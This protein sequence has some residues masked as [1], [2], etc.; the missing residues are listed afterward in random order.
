MSD[1]VVPDQVD[2]RVW[3][4]ERGL[5]YP[6]P[7]ICHLLDVAAV[8]GALWDVLLHPRLR[9]RVAGELGLGV[10]EARA[11]LAWWAGLHDLGKITPPFQAQVPDAFRALTGD[12]V[13]VAAAG[14]E[15]LAGFR[16]ELGTHW[17]LVSL[18]AEA[19]YPVSRVQARS[20]PHQVA[21]LLGGHHGCFADV[22]PPRQAAA[23]GQYQAGLGQRGWQ[24]QRRC[25]LEAV[26]RVVGAETVPAGQLSAAT[27]VRVYGL[28]VLAD[29]LAS[30]VE[31]I[32]PGLPSRTWPGS[33]EQL[34][35]HYRQ[36]ARDAPGVV[37]TAR[38]GRTEF[39]R[40]K[41]LKFEELFP[42][43]PNALQQD[44]AEVLPGLVGQ[45]GSGLVLVTA[46]T[47]D[48]KTEAALFAAATLGRASGARGV[49]FALP[50]MATAD[51][52]FPRV[53]SFAERVLT[54][55]R[56]LLLMHSAAW[57][58]PA[59]DGVQGGRATDTWSLKETVGQGEQDAD[60]SDDE[61]SAAPATAVE[62]RAWLREGGKR[63][64]VAPLGAGTIDQALA[65]VLLVSFNALR[66]F[67]LSDK[68]LIVD[69]AHAYGPW[70][71][72]LMVRLLE[73]L[74]ALRA[75]VVLLSATLTGRSASSL[76]DAYRRGAGY[77]AP[78]NIQPAYPG[79]LFTDAATGEVSHA[80]AVAT[81]RPRTLDLS[82]R[83]V[84]WDCDD[85]E[86]RLKPGGR[87][88]V[89]REVLAPVA[90]FGGTALVCCTTV[91]E[92]QRT[93]RDLRRAFP[94]LARRKGG[95]RLL[96][97]RFPGLLRQEITA[98][99]EHAYGKPGPDEQPC[100]RP[101][102]ILVATQIVEQSLDFDFDLVVSD[103]APLALLLQRAGR[104]RRHARGA[105]GRPHWARAEERPA[106]VILEP[107]GPD[108][109]TEPPRSWGDVYDHSLLLRSAALLR[110]KAGQGIAVPGDVQHLVDAVYAQ[111]FTDRLK[112]AGGEEAEAAARRLHAL[113]QRRTG[114]Q[115]AEET[116]AVMTGI[117]PP[118][119]VRGDLS[120]LSKGTAEMTAE[121]LT[122]RLGADTGRLLMLF[123]QDAG[124]VSLD[125]DGRLPM[126]DKGAPDRAAVRRIVARAVP[127]PGSWLPPA[128]ERPDL[129]AAWRKQTHLRDLV[130]V[131]MVR[132]AEG[133][134]GAVWHGQL[135]GRRV[136]FTRET[137][138]DRI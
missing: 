105:A 84:T 81:L 111:D 77:T 35:A 30:S 26:R 92:A 43:T 23:A 76:V 115:I 57:L 54:G 116:L 68:V 124:G 1:V 2:V 58:S 41:A 127:V 78:C 36:A 28:V 63:G 96:H 56:A 128:G 71:Q 21:Q 25:H 31:W 88:G 83:Q 29:W 74:G 138:I 135:D 125:E 44:I 12:G 40:K 8:F 5:P 134:E 119:A 90:E 65:A 108:G 104:G 113:D 9:A 37:A 48:G 72:T 89:L 42:F 69:E 73:W 22:V 82:L 52:M 85:S 86:A 17:A 129:P 50:T 3:G 38:L 109:A 118:Y 97:S 51:Q 117:S 120:L 122:T 64:F 136:E 87:R 45:E 59:M 75:P 110:E 131:P 103:L 27:S 49:Y 66:L 11:V 95:L 55:E 20:L 106:L 93:F 114:A 16:H 94:A 15:R 46:P 47:G 24:E 99:C 70:M 14:A 100:A 10:G 60:A 126:P 62:A 7:L 32:L 123:T 133:S 137:G 39:P 130:L 80:R 107:T 53:A 13:Y 91:A 79:W 61:F 4:K 112:E 98:D 6:Y 33:A 34:D 121:L 19:G 102:S 101:A 18:L 132:T 67:G